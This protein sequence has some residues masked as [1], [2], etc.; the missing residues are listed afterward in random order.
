MDE[1]TRFPRAAA[2]DLIRVFSQMANKR[3]LSDFA[4][5]DSK[6]KTC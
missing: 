4:L 1:G 3:K 2:Y 5:A 6:E